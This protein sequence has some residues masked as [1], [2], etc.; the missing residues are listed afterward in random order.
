MS[1]ISGYESLL[2]ELILKNGVGIGSWRVLKTK[3]FLILSASFVLF[4]RATSQ[5]IAC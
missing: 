2:R 4:S 1:N 3:I 5:K